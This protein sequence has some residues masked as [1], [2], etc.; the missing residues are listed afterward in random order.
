[1]NPPAELPPHFSDPQMPKPRSG[2]TPVGASVQTESLSAAG[3][4][5]GTQPGPT[6]QPPPEEGKS[7]PPLAPAGPETSPLSLEE[8]LE[9]LETIVRRLEEGQP[10]LEESLAQYEEGVRLLRHCYQLLENAER[11]IQLLSGVDAQGNPILKPFEDRP[12]SL[13][14]K[15]QSRDLRRTGASFTPPSE[16]QNNSLPAS[17]GL[18]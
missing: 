2:Q 6:L 1:M 18:F 14:E 9:R 16:G 15:A 11:R 12:L 5:P 4:D 10:T 7:S 3:P 17:G 8:A 13:E